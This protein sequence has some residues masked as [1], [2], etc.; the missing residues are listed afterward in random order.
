M[1]KLFWI[2]TTALGVHVLNAQTV[3]EIL[4]VGTVHEFQDSLIY[5][6]NFDA[7]HKVWAEFN[8]D[9]I[10]IESIP[11]WDTVSLQQVRATSLRAA[12]RLREEKQLSESMLQNCLITNQLNLTNNPSDLVARSMLANC[13]YASHDFWNA[14]YHWFIIQTEI[15]HNTNLKTQQLT[16]TYA[17]DSIHTRVYNIQL[18]TEFGTMVFPL[19]K[20]LNIQYLENIDDRADDTE[21]TKLSKSLPKRLLLNLKLFKALKLYNGLKKETMN[22]EISGSLIEKVNSESFQQ[23]ITEA[24][25]KLPENWVKSKKTRRIQE[26][27]YQRNF[28][29]AE[30]I[31]QVIAEKETKRIIVFVG[32]AHVEFI[33]RELKKNHQ[34]IVNAYRPK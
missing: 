1:N 6:Q 22:A 7:H 15:Q 31:N 17:L 21:F 27:W 11:P 24:I 4:V 29:M 3:P 32:A 12:K 26:L 2:L 34:F 30:R 8:P 33:V 10:C 18:T 19:A 28:R 23:I 5:K 9:M 25:D 16:E 13:L 20:A 14:Y